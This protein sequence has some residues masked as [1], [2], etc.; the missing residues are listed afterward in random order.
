MFHGGGVFSS[1]VSQLITLEYH[2][3]FMALLNEASVLPCVT[4]ELSMGN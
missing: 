2:W 1:I 4:H 3:C